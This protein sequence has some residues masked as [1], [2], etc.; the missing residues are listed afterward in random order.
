VK[1]LALK[2]A[3]RLCACGCGGDAPIA[4]QTKAKWGHIAGQPMKFIRGHGNTKHRKVNLPEYW[5]WRSMKDRC[6]NPVHK[7]FPYYGGRGIT[8]CAVWRDSFV[9]FLQD[10][11]LRPSPDYSLDRYPNNNGNYE[12]GNVRWATTVQQQ[13][14]T[15]KN[16][17]FI[18]EGEVLC[19]STLAKKLNLNS[20][21]LW[22]KLRRGKLQVKELKQSA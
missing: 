9:N 7:S 2:L 16:R 4:T 19:L 18:Y 12:P 5:A 3:S 10:V 6:F 20:G 22:Y 13:Q 11:G 17:F 1:N 8:V 15:R 14:N 21:T